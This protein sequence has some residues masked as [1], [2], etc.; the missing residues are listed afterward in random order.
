MPLCQPGPLQ[1]LGPKPGPL[2][3]ATMHRHAQRRGFQSFRQPK[4]RMDPRHL[5]G[6]DTDV[7]RL[8]EMPARDDHL[9]ER[10]V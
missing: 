8:Q 1:R 3:S 4:L 7:P 5:H 9:D 2:N 6:V 10:E